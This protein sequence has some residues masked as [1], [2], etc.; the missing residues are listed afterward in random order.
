MQ[1]P[2]PK[3]VTSTSRRPGL[4]LGPLGPNDACPTCGGALSVRPAHPY[5]VGLTAAF[6]LSFL[7]F[8]GMQGTPWILAHRNVLY[9]WTMLQAALGLALV[10]ARLRARKRVYR[11]VRCDA[12]LP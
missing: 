10:R 5:P 4:A 3:L 11:C 1:T 8:L 9:A 2:K 7:V 6:G 12:A